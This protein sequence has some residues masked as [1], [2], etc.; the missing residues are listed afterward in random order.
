MTATK[1]TINVELHPAELAPLEA[2]HPPANTPVL[3]P[4]QPHEYTEEEPFTCLNRC[5]RHC[6]RC[7]VVLEEGMRT[8]LA[9]LDFG[10]NSSLSPARRPSW[11]DSAL[12]ERAQRPSLG[13]ACARARG[14]RGLAAG[15]Y[16]RLWIDLDWCVSD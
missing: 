13:A 6:T 16:L 4:A 7:T 15:A 8:F 11:R 9:L 14:G 1:V 2:G 5:E 12:A 3:K 10:G